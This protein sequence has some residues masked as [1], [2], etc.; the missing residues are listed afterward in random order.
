MQI[1]PFGFEFMT[2][3]D[4]LLEALSVSLEHGIHLTVQLAL[5]MPCGSCPAIA[6]EKCCDHY[7]SRGYRSG[8]AVVF[9]AKKNDGQREVVHVHD[10][11][12]IFPRKS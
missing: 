5:S 2:E 7:K 1:Q 6:S 12:A 10:L 8:D 3:E 11:H 4:M 9:V